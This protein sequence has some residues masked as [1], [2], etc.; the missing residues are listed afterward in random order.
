M[1]YV[2]LCCVVYLRQFSNENPPSAGGAGVYGSL[3][4]DWASDAMSLR[5]RM[6]SIED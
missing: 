6:I 3:T 2:V 4:L 1:C 5:V